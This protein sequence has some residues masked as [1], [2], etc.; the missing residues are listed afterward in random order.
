M[1]DPTSLADHLADALAQV[2]ALRTAPRV[3]SATSWR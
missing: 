1:N 2:E 3:E